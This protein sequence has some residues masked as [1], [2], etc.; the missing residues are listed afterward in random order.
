MLP[1]V[2]QTSHVALYAFL[3]CASILAL[4]GCGEKPVVSTAGQTATAGGVEFQVGTYDIKY[5]QL[6]EGAKTF[7]YPKAVMIVPITITNK[8]KQALPYAPSHKATNANE[9]STPLLYADP[10][11]EQTLPPASKTPIPGIVFKKGT[12]AGQQT[13]SATIAAG[14]SL[15]DLLVFEVPPKGLS[16]LVLSLPPTYHRGKVPV[17]F[18]VP[19]TAKTPKGPAVNKPGEA[20]TLSGVDLT[21]N[22]NEIAY[23]E[24][25]DTADGKGYSAEPLLKISYTIKNGTDKDIIYTPNHKV[26]GAVGIKLSSA[27]EGSYKRVMFGATTSAVGQKLGKTSIKAGASI[28]DYVLFER[29]GKDVDK[30]L[31][32]FP[33]SLFKAKGIA[34]IE[35]P[36]TYAEPKPPTAKKKAPKPDEK[37][38]EKK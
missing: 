4:S 27:D 2:Q 36:Y 24:T 30:L 14:E 35:L 20:I 10:G 11:P 19:Y 13:E 6:N 28:K 25:S 16:S 32:E 22:G 23:I 17:L 38:E 34:R 1:D 18:R 31:M 8:G 7:E 5:V 15:K 9:A 37:K 26:T 3:A 33:G 12:L 29:P 21:V